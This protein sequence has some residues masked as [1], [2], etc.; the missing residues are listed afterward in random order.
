MAKGS[1]IEFH[2]EDFH[3]YTMQT[4]EGQSVC[5][6][7]IDR[8]Y[9]D[10]TGV[11]GEVTV[12][13]LFEGEPKFPVVAYQRCNLIQDKR[14][15]IDML[16]ERSD[17]WPWEEFYE[18]AKSMTVDAARR[19]APV[20]PLQ[21]IGDEAYPPFLIEPFV[22]DRGV[23]LLFGPGGT[24]KS[25][26]ALAMAVGVASGRTIFGRKPE[27]VGPV[28]YLDYEDSRETHE[29]RL[30]ALL[31]GM[32]MS[33]DELE[34]PILWVKPMQPISKMR[35]DLNHYVREYRP[36][37]LIVD[38]VGLARGGDAMG[39]DETIRLF[40]TLNR[41]P[42]AVL[43]I[44]HM[45]KEDQRSGKMLT[46]YGSIYT[47]NSVRLAWAVK[48][49]EA[50]SSEITYLSLRQTKRNNV[51]AHD[52]LGAEIRFD[53][54]MVEFNHSTQP[55]LREVKV[56]LT[57]QWWETHT[58]SLVDRLLEALDRENMTARELGVRLEEPNTETI[59]A[60]LRRLAKEGRVRRVTSGKPMVWGLPQDAEVSE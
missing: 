42:A 49:A 31:S 3:S 9:L 16:I 19:P 7:E 51:A 32:E 43:G 1:F 57:D 13:Y 24:G 50:S 15:G 14:P 26:L 56:G 58:G 18:K 39:S 4:G 27:Q 60:T 36:A 2:D 44:D 45:T 30:T 48:A 52:P 47:V 25:M 37:L 8:V 20:A 33:H 29:R 12:W 10:K 46:P 40:G 5:R 17:V 35:R 59:G 38:S 53:N 55:I 22:L 34:H 28:L 23:S 41:L 6:F 11:W 54:E 21:P